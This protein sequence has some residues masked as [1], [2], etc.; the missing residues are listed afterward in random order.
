ML[1]AEQQ[2]AHHNRRAAQSRRQLAGIV[3]TSAASRSA[4]SAEHQRVEA[5]LAA[6]LAALDEVDRAGSSLHRFPRERLVRIQEVRHSR[7]QTIV[8]L[9]LLK[10]VQRGCRF[11]GKGCKLQVAADSCCHRYMAMARARGMI[12]ERL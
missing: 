9:N 8:R 6:L 5:Q 1:T 11:L 12:L 7:A 3:A 4:V 10:A 2:P